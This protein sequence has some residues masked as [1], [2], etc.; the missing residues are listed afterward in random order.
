MEVFYMST[1]TQVTLIICVTI[2]L[3]LIINEIGEYFKKNK[4]E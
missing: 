3:L 2:I 1:I 4:E